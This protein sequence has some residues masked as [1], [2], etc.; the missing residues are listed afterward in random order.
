MK[1]SEI[2]DMTPEE[3]SLKE[4]ELRQELFSLRMKSGVGQVEKPSLIRGLRKDIAR[5]L[6][7]QGQKEKAKD[8]VQPAAKT[9][10]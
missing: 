3:L 1:I 6:T 2:V 9:Q 8:T 4:R 7:V 10:G 5:V